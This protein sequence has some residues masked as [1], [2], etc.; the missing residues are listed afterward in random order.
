MQLSPGRM[1]LS[2]PLHRWHRIFFIGRLAEF[3]NLRSSAAAA[4]GSTWPPTHLRSASWS[5]STTSFSHKIVN[6]I[7]LVVDLPLWKI[8]VKWDY[9]SQLNGKKCS[10]P[11]TSHCVM[12]VLG[13]SVAVISNEQI[14]N[15]QQGR[16]ERM[17]LNLRTYKQEE[18]SPAQAYLWKSNIWGKY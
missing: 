13:G 11:P 4:L 9:C 1:D 12:Y 7:W 16:E 2:T 18:T 10:K 15:M 3:E 17:K 8:W 14:Y 6:T 5:G